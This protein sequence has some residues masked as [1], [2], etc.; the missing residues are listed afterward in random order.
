MRVPQGRSLPP[1]VYKTP[2]I[3]MSYDLLLSLLGI[4]IHV[5]DK[6]KETEQIQIEI[7]EML[8]IKPLK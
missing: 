3:K 2:K 6:I 5:K 4:R 8:R 7:M 1:P